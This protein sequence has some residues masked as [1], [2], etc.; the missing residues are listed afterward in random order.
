MTDEP[1]WIRGGR[2][3]KKPPRTV[4]DRKNAYYN[5]MIRSGYSPERARELTERWFDAQKKRAGEK[6]GGEGA[7]G[8]E[9]D[10]KSVPW[11][12]KL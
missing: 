11:W 5:G 8:I 10:N 9:V 1:K 12:K 6:V 4:E 3:N 7:A 2:G